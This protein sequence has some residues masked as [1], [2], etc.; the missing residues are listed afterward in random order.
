MEKIV[1]I[2][3]RKCSDKM[4]WIGIAAS[5]RYALCFFHHLQLQNLYRI[6]YMRIYSFFLGGWWWFNQSNHESVIFGT[7]AC[8]NY[9]FCFKFASSAIRI[10]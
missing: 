9:I 2:S 5:C 10:S 3:S 4:Q 8:V 6:K 7:T 1:L